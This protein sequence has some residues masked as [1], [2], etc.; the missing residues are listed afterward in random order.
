MMSSRWYHPLASA[1]ALLVWV[2]G[3]GQ[4]GRADSR[5]ISIA[6]GGTGGVYYP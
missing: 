1:L 4:S 2:G 6:T 5:F 3:C